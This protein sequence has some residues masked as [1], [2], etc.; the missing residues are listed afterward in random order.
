VIIDRDS[1]INIAT[2]RPVSLE[3]PGSWCG[4]LPFAAWIINQLKPD[5]FVELGTHSG[6]SYFSFCQ[7]VQENQL[8]TKCFAVDTWQ[9]DEHSGK[10]DDSVFRKVVSTNAQNYATF[11]TLLQTTFDDAVQSFA[12]NSIGLLHIDGLH[13]YEA[14]KHDFETWLPKLAH[15]AVVLFHDTTVRERGFGVWK[16]WAE[17]REKYPN[18]I[19]FVHSYG[20]GVL[21][22]NNSGADASLAWLAADYSEKQFIREFFAKLGNNQFERFVAA[23]TSVEAAK[24]SQ[25]LSERD[26]QQSERDAQLSERSAQLA[27]RDA[28][29]SERSAQL[30]ERDAQLSERSAQLAERDAQLSE[31]S[32]Q[33]AERDA[34]L[35]EQDVQLAERDARLS[36]QDVQLAER[37]VQ[38][39]ERSA[40]LAERDAQLSERGAQLA[41]RDARLTEQDARLS[42]RDVRVAELTQEIDALRQS[43]SWRITKPLRFAG[44]QV[45][46]VKSL[47]RI[48]PAT[49]RLGGGLRAT[50]K[51]TISLY[52]REGLSGLKRGFRRIHAVGEIKPTA[53]S[54]TFDRNDYAEWVRRYDT[55]DDAQRK[56]IKALCEELDYQPKISVI[57]PVYNPKPEWLIEAIESVRGQ[58]YTNWELCIA[59]D[60]SPDPAIRP[61]LERFAY[62]D[63]RIKV[64]FRDHN[65][66]IS[67]ASNTAL[68]LAS[69]EWIALLDHDDVLTEHA[70]FWIANQINITPNAQLIYSDEDK[71]DDKNNRIDPYF[72]CDWNPNLFY[73]HN[74]ITHLGAYKKSII[75]KIRG[76][77]MGFEGAQDYDLALRCIEQI[78]STEIVHIPRIL[79]HWRVHNKSTAGSIDAKPYALHAG[80]KALDEHFLRTG[81]PASVEIGEFGYQVKFTLPKNLPKVSI[82]IPTR[83]AKALVEKC[84]TSVQRK[85]TYPTWEIILVDNGSDDPAS[86]AYFEE[87]K[88]SGIRVL[89]DDSAF[90]YSS[91]NNL[92][93]NVASGQLLCFM[94]NDIEVISPN[95]LSDMVSHALRQDTG[96]VGAKLLYPD[97]TIQHAGVVLG[98]GG[99]AGHSHKGYHRH[100]PG[101]VGRVGLISNFSAVTGACMVLRRDNF[102]SVGGFDEKN[103][104]IACNDVDL[105]LK[106]TEKGLLN[107]YLPQVELYHHESATRGYEDTAEKKDR[108]AREVA[109]MHEKWGGRLNKDPYYSPNL[110]LSHEDFSLAWPPRTVSLQQ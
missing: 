9:G 63:N 45:A 104:A 1:L 80:K 62:E 57:M 2:F 96:A 68:T 39:F 58:I 5:V 15:G 6:N 71:I 20:L 30:A 66:H 75:D 51:K 49:I 52:Q 84:I 94:N 67:A 92:A 29:L 25:M 60:A 97:D 33:L 59:D 98:I 44:H 48:V 87:L 17:L 81:Q 74:Q 86:L 54:N 31:R 100:H 65:G 61:I 8:S 82:I 38:L 23:Q 35:S 32:A 27:E 89:R 16:L 55:I 78:K 21:Q 83:N 105:C 99:W 14:V 53:V 43:T 79:Y 24:L 88:G 85:T 36:E 76:F 12:D 37:D 107:I 56:K 102:L 77:R 26:A 18:N 108:F 40:Q 47:L 10:Y 3:F 42:E 19:E 70:L 4:H 95:W 34:R 11:S 101:Y 69:G 28:Q 109:H 106:L 73:S 46:R 72:K 93:A 13:T 7:S 50:I 103:L 90:N 91:L 22:L 64:V 110:T 41:E